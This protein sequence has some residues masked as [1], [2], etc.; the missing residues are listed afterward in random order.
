MDR[1][2]INHRVFAISFWIVLTAVKT[3]CLFPFSFD[4]NKQQLKRHR[5]PFVY[6]TIF[7]VSL[8]ATVLHSTRIVAAHSVALVTSDAITLALGLMFLTYAFCVLFTYIRAYTNLSEIEAI[9][10][11]C[12]RIV[13]V[14][15]YLQIKPNQ[16]YTD[17][18][19]RFSIN[20]FLLPLL[21]IWANYG[22]LMYSDLESSKH[23]IPIALVAI[24]RVIPGVVK[25]LFYGSMLTVFYIFRL[26]NLEI[27][28]I[29]AKTTEMEAGILTPFKIQQSFCDLSDSL[30]SIAQAHLQLTRLAQRISDLTMFNLVLWVAYKVFGILLQLF[31][32]YKYSICLFTSDIEKMHSPVLALEI[33]FASLLIWVLEIFM[34]TDACSKTMNE[35]S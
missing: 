29:M 10:E 31:T 18:L 22:R 30:D 21:V 32:L 33:T 24:P 8:T 7:L 19:L 6:P 35:V 20:F 11:D 23:V 15:K 4:K 14:F 1:R 16:S 26:L 9:F 2:T 17:L 3:F 12:V 34:V 25:G 27:Q 28:S 13:R 5:F